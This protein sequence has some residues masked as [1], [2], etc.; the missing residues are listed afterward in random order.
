MSP[1]RFYNVLG[2]F[3]YALSRIGCVALIFMMALTV[4]DVTGRYVFNSPILGAFELTEFMVL[5][6]VFSY[7]AYAQSQ[8]AHVTVDLLVN[9]FPKPL[10]RGIDLFNHTISIILLVL[11]T[12]KGYDKI[13]ETYQGG[14]KPM[15]LPVADWP[16]VIFM[17]IGCAALCIEYLRDIIKV[18]LK[19]QKGGDN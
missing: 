2:I 5:L 16:F 18:F 11:I 13:I 7:L 15:N 6:V 14:D 10:Q 3:S 8:N 4:V 1:R 9:L 12:W 19:E 17:T